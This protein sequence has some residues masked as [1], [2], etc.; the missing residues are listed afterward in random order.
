MTKPIK[1]GKFIGADYIPC[2]TARGTWCWRRPDIP[3]DPHWPG[4]SAPKW[5]TGVIYKDASWHWSDEADATV[6]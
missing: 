2:R 3:E 6:L 4:I 5:A 1:D